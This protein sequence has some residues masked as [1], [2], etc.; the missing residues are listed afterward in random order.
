M[1]TLPV[2]G[3]LQE[4]SLTCLELPKKA[5]APICHVE[6]L[7]SEWEAAGGYLYFRYEP[8]KLTDA[9]ALKSQA[10]QQSRKCVA[11][12]LGSLVQHAVL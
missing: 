9:D 11:C 8:G 1:S 2:R 10:G 12:I 4:Q 3:Y 5:M 6:P 7:P